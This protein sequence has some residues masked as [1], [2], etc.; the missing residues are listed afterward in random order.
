M[1][2]PYRKRKPANFLTLLI[3]C[4]VTW[5]IILSTWWWLPALMEIIN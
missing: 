1:P 3:W 2:D 4:I 5:L